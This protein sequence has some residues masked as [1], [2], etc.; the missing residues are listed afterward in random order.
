MH[1]SMSSG[2]SGSIAL[3]YPPS[4]LSG[5]TSPLAFPA[6]ARRTAALRTGMLPLALRPLR[7]P[8]LPQDIKILISDSSLSER[9]WTSV[10]NQG[11]YFLGEFSAGAKCIA[12]AV[13]FA[14]V[15]I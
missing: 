4:S 3:S 12:D 11:G 6:D 15:S 13:A 1:G 8:A 5:T 7:M 2:K 9:L 14:A 10:I